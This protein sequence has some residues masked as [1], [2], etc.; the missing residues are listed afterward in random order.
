MHII[1]ESLYMAV[2]ANHLSS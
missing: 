1:Y 2:W